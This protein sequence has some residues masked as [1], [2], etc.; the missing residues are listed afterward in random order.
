LVI[1][2]NDPEVVGRQYQSFANAFAY[3]AGLV[4]PPSQSDRWSIRFSG[5]HTENIIIPEFVNLK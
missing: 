5:T 3:L 4:T 2:V 1:N